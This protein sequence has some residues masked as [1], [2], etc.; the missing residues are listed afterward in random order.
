VALPIAFHVHLDA[1]QTFSLR[2]PPADCPGLDA[3]VVLSAGKRILLSAYSTS[4]EPADNSRPGNGRHGTYR[5][6]ADIPADRRSGAVTFRT[7][8]GEATAFTQPYYECTNS[9][10]DYTEPVAVITLDHPRDTAY[11]ALVVYGDKG[12]ISLDRLTTVLKTQL[13]P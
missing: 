1:D 3:V 12:T 2:T 5:S 13:S 10:H 9:C 7:P 4:C 8:L 6:T 11:R